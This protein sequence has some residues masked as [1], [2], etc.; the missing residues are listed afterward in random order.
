MIVGKVVVQKNTGPDKKVLFNGEVE[1][2]LHQVR[3]LLINIPTESKVNTVI[4]R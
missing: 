3:F 4:D 1:W 2:T